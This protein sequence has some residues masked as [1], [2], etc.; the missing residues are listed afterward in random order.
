MIKEIVISSLLL[1]SP[2]SS[3]NKS[4]D[5]DAPETGFKKLSWYQFKDSSNFG[6][7]S[8]GNVDLLAK[9][10][11]EDK[12]I[13]GITFKENGFLYA[14]NIGEINGEEYTDFSDLIN[15]SFSVSLRAYLRSNDGGANY[16]FS[17][18]S[19]GSH[20]DLQWVYGG[21]SIHGSNIDDLTLTN[22]EKPL[23]STNF[24]WYRI[25]IIYDDS[26]KSFKFTIKSEEENGT[27]YTYLKTLSTPLKFGGNS[28]YSFTIGA[29]SHLGEWDDAHATATLNDGQVIAPSLSDFRIYLGA[30]DDAEINEIASYD[31][32]NLEE[33]ERIQ[34]ERKE[35]ASYDFIDS[36]NLLKDKI[37]YMDLI[38]KGTNIS[39]ED[40]Y[41]KLE[42]NCLSLPKIMFNND[43]V[44]YLDSYTIGFDIKQ[45]AMSDDKEHIILSVDEKRGLYL[46]IKGNDLIASFGNNNKK[47]LS[48]IFTSNEENYSILLNVNKDNTNVYINS[49]NNVLNGIDVITKGSSSLTFGG[50][51]SFTTNSEC[52]NSL[53]IKNIKLYDFNFNNTQVNQYFNN[54][55]I[56]GKVAK[57]INV[58]NIY[59]NLE[60]EKTETS[61]DLLKEVLPSKVKVT[62]QLN[63][64][65]DA[66]IIWTK[67]IKNDSGFDVYGFING[68]NVNN[69]DNLP[70][71]LV[72]PFIIDKSEY[73]QIKPIAWYQFNDA[74]NIGKDS[75]G[76]FDLLLGGLQQVEHHANDGYVTFKK[77]NKSYLYAPAINNGK[78][79]SDLLSGSYTVSID[80]NFDNTINDGSQYAITTSSYGEGFLLYG[81]YDGIE[82]VY[83]SGGYSSH[84]LIYSTGSLKNSWTTLTVS[85]DKEKST[86]SFFVNGQLFRTQKVDNINNFSSND[87]YT[88]ALGAQA[89][90]TGADGAQFFE[91]SMRNVK[92]YDFALSKKNVNDLIKNQLDSSVYQETYVKEVMPIENVDSIISDTNSIDK[93][94][95]NLPQQVNVKYSDNTIKLASVTWIG[96]KNGNIVGYLTNTDYPNISSLMV[97]CPIYYRIDFVKS[98]SI[99]LEDVMVNGLQ[100]QES[101][102]YRVNDEVNIEFKIK[103]N[104]FYKISSVSVNGKE[105][106]PDKDNIYHI[107]ITDYSNIRINSIANEY[108]ITYVLNNGQNDVTINYS[109]GEDKKLD[110]YFTKDGYTFDGWY[111]NSDCTGER[112]DTIDTLNPKDITL[113]AKWA[114]NNSKQ[115]NN[116]CK[117]TLNYSLPLA[118]VGISIFIYKK[119]KGEKNENI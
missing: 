34:Y 118:L 49:I 50:T 73:K 74:T 112:I 3:F 10:I 79:F 93:I 56:T 116:G 111:L 83:S 29:Q 87:I 51:S 7:D 72:V 82:V 104:S 15:G 75:M 14:N 59:T 91:G 25:N 20:F 53:L 36:N 115:N 41:L 109:Y 119:R 85:V 42:N 30:I 13:G 99:N 65:I 67:A 9:N 28:K 97:Y 48:S 17:S 77:D 84:K 110:S 101:N 43:V 78:D 1:L 105:I 86:V 27:D 90:I 2:F 70:I 52:I 57:V 19:Y 24:E 80:L 103:T 16:L 22:E 45:K 47:T 94:K 39:K 89:T 63:N 98:N 55:K 8:L 40:S 81:C 68:E 46:A 5:F 18:G 76:N 108:K 114:K 107:T 66:N 58:A 96:Y 100:Y 32:N 12:A 38:A 64:I 33:Q 54:E 69:F 106:L 23:L 88:F 61:N 60:V 6:K 37:G 44:D 31:K 95:D 26:N 102:T 92:V 11:V 117:S 62:T 71:H 35:I 4:I 21:F 113:Y